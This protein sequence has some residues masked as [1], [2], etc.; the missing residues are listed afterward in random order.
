MTI[1]K[2]PRQLTKEQLRVVNESGKTIYRIAQET[3]LRYQTVFNAV[4][5]TSNVEMST[6]AA[7][8]RSLGY[9]IDDFEQLA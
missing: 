8:A 4:K 5:K 3:G 2:Y 6:V 1:L 7:I 9:S